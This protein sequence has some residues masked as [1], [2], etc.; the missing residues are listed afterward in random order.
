MSRQFD[1]VCLG[2][3]P[4][5]EAITAELKGSG[6]SLAVIESALVGGECPYWGCIPSKTLLRSGEVL[7]EAGRARDLA[8]ARVEW[9]VDFHKIAARTSW[10]ARDWNDAGA[11][12]ALIDQGAEV[13]RGV[14]RLAGPG[15]VEVGDEVLEARRAVVVATGTRPAIPPIPGLEGIEPWTNRDAVSTKE[16]PESLVV[17]GGGAAGVELG[18][19]FARF[20]CRVTVLQTLDRLVANEEPEAGT[21]LGEAFADEG[22][23]VRTNVR[24]ERVDRAGLGVRVYLADGFTVEAERLLLGTGRNPNLDGFAL[25]AAGAKAA[26]N[27]FLEVDHETLLAADG[28]YGGGDVTTIGGFTH[29]AH[30][31]GTVIGRR[32]RGET[33]KAFMAAVPRVTFTDPEIGSVGLTEAQAR[34]RGIDVQVVTADVPTTA[35]GYIHDAKRGIVKVVADRSARVVVGAT[36]VSPHAGE[37]LTELTLAI[38]AGIGLDLLD[39]TLHAFP[40]FSRVLQGVFAE[41]RN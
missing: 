22:I 30:Y 2:A 17:I 9:T 24:I 8:A 31:H 19:A 1:V 40:T 3:G 4:C 5:G 13:I 15:R 41:F 29:V 37:M 28:V 7:T 36:I 38:R 14:A 39:D 23:D 35:R 25:D 6:L 32:L 21:I 26:G 27:G 20:G 12:Q 33:V 34:A 10:M 18:Q 11:A 16:L